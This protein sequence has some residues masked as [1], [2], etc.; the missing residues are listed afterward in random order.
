MKKVKSKKELLIKL[1]INLVVSLGLFFLIF[2]TRFK[3]DHYII[4]AFTLTGVVLLLF[5][6]LRFVISEGVFHSIEW[7]IKKFTDFFR[8]VP[9]YN[10]TYHDFIAIKE[11]KDR[12]L[13][14]PTLL[15]GS[16][17]LAIGV[18]MIICIS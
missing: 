11:E 16:I 4:D 17:Y 14:W 18:V 7:S 6:S 12:P 13:L 8:R 2:F 3:V 15:I 9:K 1:I 10:Y 5:A